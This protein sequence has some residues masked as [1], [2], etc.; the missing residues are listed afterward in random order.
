MR[1]DPETYVNEILRH[2]GASTPWQL[3]TELVQKRV[4]STSSLVKQER[5]IPELVQWYIADQLL[6][7]TERLNELLEGRVSS[8]V[9]ELR[10]IRGTTRLSW[11][12]LK[13][14]IELS[15][16]YPKDWPTTPT[17]QF[18]ISALAT[19]AASANPSALV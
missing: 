14:S 17:T 8:W 16:L 12:I 11:R 6:E 18:L 4:W 1:D 2:I 13:S 3:P 7:P 19:L 10:E 15:C 5:D 9:E